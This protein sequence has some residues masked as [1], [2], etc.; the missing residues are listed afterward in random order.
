MEDHELTKLLEQLHHEIERTKTVDDKEKELLRD[1]GA[2]IDEL[3]GRTP[4]DRI[5][6]S[7]FTLQL[8]E[9]TIDQFEATHPTLTATLSKLFAVLSNAGI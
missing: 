4:S 6:P 7:P 3:L 2:H 9:E 5:A 8:L 1:L